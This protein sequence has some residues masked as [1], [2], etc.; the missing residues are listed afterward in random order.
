MKKNYVMV[1]WFILAILPICGLEGSD[2]TALGELDSL[3]ADYKELVPTLPNSWVSVPRIFN[4]TEVRRLQEEVLDDTRLKEYVE[5]FQYGFRALDG[6]SLN[7]WKDRIVQAVKIIKKLNKSV[8]DSCCSSSASKQLNSLAWMFRDRTRSLQFAFIDDLTKAST[9][10]DVL[11][12]VLSRGYFELINW[13]LADAQPGLEGFLARLKDLLMEGLSR[14]G[15]LEGKLKLLDEQKLVLAEC[16]LVLRDAQ[17]LFILAAGVDYLRI[18]DEKTGL[19]IAQQSLD[20]ALQRRKQQQLLAEQQASARTVAAERAVAV[21]EK[22]AQAA[23][24]LAKMKSRY[25]AERLE[26][27]KNAQAGGAAAVQAAR[28]VLEQA[29]IAVSVADLELA[30]ADLEATA[31]KNE[32]EALAAKHQG[33]REVLAAELAEIAA[34]ADLN[35]T[36]RRIFFD[37]IDRQIAAK[38]FEEKLVQEKRARA[39][40]QQSEHRAGLALVEQRVAV[41][42]RKLMAEAGVT[43]AKAEV[44][45]AL[46]EERKQDTV[47]ARVGMD[48]DKVNNKHRRLL[49]PILAG[50]SIG[51]MLAYFAI[52]H[53]YKPR[54]TIIERKDT[55]RRTLSE[56]IKGLKT[57][58]SNLDQVILEPGLYDQVLGKF[59]GIEQAIKVGLPMSNML[60]YGPSGTG[61]TMSAQAF[62]RNLSEKKLADHVIVRGAAFKRLGSPGKAQKA[63]ADVLRWASSGK[64]PVVL[65]FD[66]AETMF[67]DRSLP[68]ANEMTNDLV[69]TMLSFFERGVSD[70][71]MFILSTNYPDR[72]DQALLNRIDPSNRVRFTPPGQ[73]E[74]EQLLEGYIKQHVLDKKFTVHEDVFRDKQEIAQRMNGLVGRQIDS[75][76]AQTLYALLSKNSTQLDKRTLEQAIDRVIKSKALMVS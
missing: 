73:N 72:I 5:Q 58:R 41:E 48:R 64:L 55:S 31:K 13:S 17:R 67:V 37:D 42:V 9:P 36:Q 6:A 57:P 2:A 35:R 69:A 23:A 16:E 56:K 38:E 46:A 39:A 24:E 66:E 49:V 60:F 12:L 4:Q 15:V 45:E 44:E 27:L 65:V 43:N 63:L 29:R 32:A 74:R 33:E 40:V 8:Y 20:A 71:I 30:T 3:V 52:R 25:A 18:D 22:E 75:L 68:Y 59:Q 61:K 62:C 47:L 11:K 51:V 54:P 70:K 34:L 10:I 76:V 50:S 53:Y 14:S 19:V 1:G 7:F 28:E 26:A 21:Q